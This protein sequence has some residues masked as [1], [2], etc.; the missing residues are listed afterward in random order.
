MYS[1]GTNEL[2]TFLQIS[3]PR[4]IKQVILQKYEDGIESKF[5]KPHNTKI[6]FKW[7]YVY[8]RWVRAKRFWR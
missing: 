6:Y 2:L 3:L 4:E 5:W 8:T 1:I 7:K